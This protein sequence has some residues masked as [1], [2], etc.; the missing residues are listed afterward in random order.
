MQIREGQK[1]D[2]YP[3]VQGWQIY[4]MC[5]KSHGAL[6]DMEASV[7]HLKTFELSGKS[8]VGCPP[9]RK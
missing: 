6:R 3:L 7:Q 5:V 9:P 2:N 1:T 4:G 8:L